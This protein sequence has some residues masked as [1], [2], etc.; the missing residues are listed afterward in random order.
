[1][2]MGHGFNNFW[3]RNYTNAAAITIHEACFQM[4]AAKKRNRKGV[5]EMEE[6][7]ENNM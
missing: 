2:M 5:L 3:D 4:G 1:M 6:D 7:H